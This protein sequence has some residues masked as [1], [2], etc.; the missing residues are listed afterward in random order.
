[1]H[2]SVLLSV[3]VIVDLKVKQATQE[4]KDQEDHV[5]SPAAVARQALLENSAIPE[6]KE[7]RDPQARRV[8]VDRWVPRV[9][10]DPQAPMDLKALRGQQ[11]LM[12]ITA[13][14]AH[15][16]NM[17]RAE[18]LEKSG[19]QGLAGKEAPQ[20]P[21]GIADPVERRDFVEGPEDRDRLDLTGLLDLL[22]MAVKAGTAV[23]VMMGMEDTGRMS[24]EDTGQMSMEDTC[25]MTTEKCR[26]TTEK[27]PMNTEMY[28]PHTSR[29]ALTHGT[30]AS[31]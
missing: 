25:R 13:H 12:E 18:S 21:A 29:V 16:E 5:V 3:Q 27:C 11:A 30:G 28:Q 7:S 14:R 1:M 2:A 22:G 17:A 15:L 6:V 9:R 8:T 24:M 10:Q 20:D 31:R 19:L 26:I 4:E 23:A